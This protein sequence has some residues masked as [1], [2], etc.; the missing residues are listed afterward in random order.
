MLATI[1]LNAC[2]E[3]VDVDGLADLPSLNSLNL[4]DC[5][6]LRSIEGL[7]NLTSLKRLYLQYCNNIT[8]LDALSGLRSLTELYICY[9]SN[10]TN[11]EGLAK[12]VS[13][14]TLSLSHCSGL[15]SVEYLSQLT[16][17]TV[18]DL[19]HC[20][21]LTSVEGLARLIAI[22]HLSLSSCSGLSSVKGLAK[23]TALTSLNLSFCA[24]LEDIRD[25]AGLSSL[26]TLD[27]SDCAQLCN[28]E[29]LC[30]MTA[31]AKLNL[32]KCFKLENLDGMADLP[33]IDEI[34]LSFNEALLS[35]NAISNL[36]HL[37][38]L[39]LSHCIALRHIS[40]V[41]HLLD[42]ME[43][44]YI[45]NTFFED[46]H[47]DMNEW[48]LHENPVDMLRKY[49]CAIEH[50]SQPD[51]EIKV[52]VLGNGGV[53][54]TKLIGRLLGE[55]FNSI[56]EIRT[57]GIQIPRPLTIYHGEQAIKLH[58]WDFGGQDI[59]HG[60]HSLFLT[61]PAIFMLILSDDM[62]NE[63]ESIVNGIPVKNRLIDYWFDYLVQV[64]GKDGHVEMPIVFVKNKCD[65]LVD[66]HTDSSHYSFPKDRFVRLTKL[67]R[68][69][70]KTGSGLGDIQGSLWT[71][72]Y[73][74]MS[75]YP[76]KLLPLS[77]F[78]VRED[79]RVMQQNRSPRTLSLADLATICEKHGCPGDECVV[80]DIFHRMGV[81]F[82][83]KGIFDNQIILDQ[84]W[85]LD[86]VYTIFTPNKNFQ[87]I[88]RSSGRFSRIDLMYHFWRN[89][90]R[91]EQSL[92]LSLCNSATFV[93]ISRNLGVVKIVYILLPTCSLLGE[94]SKADY[95]RGSKMLNPYVKWRPS[96]FY[97]TM[98]YFAY[99]YQKLVVS[100]WPMLSIGNTV[101][102]FM[103]KKREAR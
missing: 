52:F 99:C 70:A 68:T 26:T 12:L 7:S 71:A 51:A 96:T 6:N 54:K 38:S 5:S 66:E 27:L 53:G 103:K 47:P 13:L 41:K 97:C 76:Q 98:A 62:E 65:S 91:E 29:G 46:L 3:L 50:G 63:S 74:I 4:A 89:F 101:V 60:T 48:G 64:A 1:N 95:L 56:P 21:G 45:E 30:N 55:S 87:G 10:L 61:G 37:R 78:R 36:Q 25:L 19:S 39:N 79:L 84:S 88:I 40:P 34:D 11:I 31:L 28:L 2:E 57:H 80:R 32:S 69:S 100:R 81:V 42:K 18:L 83:R 58:F 93:S 24:E 49:Y 17:I 67:L 85:V 73:Q 9:Y 15:T 33:K 102:I 86:A 16:A 43:F 92:F 44:L 94:Q 72:V 75:N 8:N 22:T 35:I 90:S 82:Y 59:Y 77:W 23:L 14:T 20:S